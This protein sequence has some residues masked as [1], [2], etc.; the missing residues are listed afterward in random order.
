MISIPNPGSVLGDVRQWP[1]RARS[2]LGDARGA[3]R[4]AG[5]PLRARRAAVS[6]IPRPVLAPHYLPS[7]Q[8]PERVP[9]IRLAIEMDLKHR[10][11]LLIFASRA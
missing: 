5:G 10:E 7:T 9:G 1:Q 8:A 4:R 3:S 6:K 2:M 11:R